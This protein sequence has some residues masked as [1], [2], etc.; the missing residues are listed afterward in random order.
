M[1]DQRLLGNFAGVADRRVQDVTVNRIA[2]EALTVVGNGKHA[3]YK[4][5]R[6]KNKTRK[7]EARNS[8]GSEHRHFQSFP[9]TFYPSSFVLCTCFT[10]GSR[11]T[12]Q[13]PGV[14][15][16]APASRP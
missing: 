11:Q 1:I 12:A 8:I 7:Q 14:R 10:C 13:R 4:G 5:R 16:S 6:T 9:L 3:K 15:R 2:D